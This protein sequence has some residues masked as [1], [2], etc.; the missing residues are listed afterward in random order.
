VRAVIVLAAVAG[1]LVLQVAR[2][3]YTVGGSWVFDLVLVG[4]VFAALSGGPVAGL[5]SGTVGGLLQDLLSGEVAGVGG[6]AKTLVGFLAGIVGT[7]F[8]MTRAYARALVVAVASVVHRLLMLGLQAL[9]DQRWLG[10]PW[11]AILAEVLI[12]T[13]VALVVFYGVAAG[14]GLV[15]RRRA[16]RRS[17]LSRRQ[18]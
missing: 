11:G 3:R 1:G 10:V 13:T 7:Q 18:W 14:P 12:N 9:I 6:L 8:V 16:S 17:S 15:A 5:W 4:V 2:A